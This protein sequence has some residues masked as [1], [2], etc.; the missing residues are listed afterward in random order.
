[1]AT[2]K[3]SI[4]FRYDDELWK[5]IEKLKTIF[6]TNSFNKV[7]QKLVEFQLVNLPIIKRTLEEA[8][9]ELKE[10]K[11]RE[12]QLKRELNGIK[13]LLR[14]KEATEKGIKQFISEEY[15]ES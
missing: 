12:T 8:Q 7:I 4:P 2:P 10:T 15:E 11:E 6:E 13:N 5:K 14:E 9:E 3:T 1:M